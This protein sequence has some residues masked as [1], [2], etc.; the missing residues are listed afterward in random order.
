MKQSIQLLLAIVVLIAT[1]GGVAFVRNWVIT[2]DPG[3]PTE[4]GGGIELVFPVTVVED[5]REVEVK[6]HGRQDFR[7]QNPHDEP[8]E[9]GLNSKG[10]KCAKV[11]A[12]VLSEEEESKLNAMEPAQ[13]QQFLDTA[14]RWQSIEDPEGAGRLAAIPARRGGFVRLEWEAEQLGP[15]RLWATVWARAQ[16]QPKSR[17]PDTRLE[18]PL[19]VVAPVRLSTTKLD[20]PEVKAGQPQTAEFLCYSTTR[21]ELKVTAVT[22]KTN[23][24]CFVCSAKRLEG[25]EFQQAAKTLEQVTSKLVS[26]YRITVAVHQQAP[27]GT[28]QLEFGPFQRELVLRTEEKDFPELGI[29]VNGTVRGDI[30]VGTEEYPDR[31]IFKTFPFNE[32]KTVSTPL[33]TA[34][35]GTKLELVSVKPDYVQVELKPRDGGGTRWDLTTTVPARRLLGRF[36]DDSAVILRTEDDRRLRIPIVGRATQALNAR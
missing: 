19:T 6:S 5:T 10:C 13:V 29:D 34:R 21:P 11:Q 25:D 2:P 9:L 20:L 17:G 12:L 3:R 28:A 7:F 31:I 22:E 23:D 24:P 30:T 36:P 33:E 8:V 15:E 4:A 1:I 14:D 16:G 32:K 27:D 35:A 18:V 26:V